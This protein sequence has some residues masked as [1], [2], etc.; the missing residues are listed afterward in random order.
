MRS[1]HYFLAGLALGAGLLFFAASSGWVGEAAP[2]AGA[3]GDGEHDEHGG[4]GAGGGSREGHGAAV[5][6]A[7]DAQAL[8]GVETSPVARRA[9]SKTISLPAEVTIPAGRL[10]H[11]GA[12]VEGTIHHV[13]V[14]LGDAVN[15]GDLLVEIDSLVMGEAKAAYLQV[16]AERDLAEK[17]LARERKLAGEGGSARKDL[18]DAEA[19]LAKADIALRAARDRLTLL[20]LDE[21][22]IA[23]V[24]EEKGEERSH[25]PVRA[26]MTG[27]VIDRHATR[28]EVA[29]PEERLF[30]LA[31]L[32]EVWVI[33]SVAERD[34]SL[35]RTGVTA[36]ARVAADPDEVH[37]GTLTYVAPE[38]DPRTR[39]IPVRVVTPNR[40]GRLKPGMFAEVSL[41]IDGETSMLVVP[42]AA[43]VRVD[44]RPAVF[45]AEEGGRFERRM[46]R[47][48]AETRDAVEL[49][50]GV[51]EGER[52]VV[53]GAFLLK[54]ELE[55]AS[56]ADGH[57]D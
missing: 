32:D 40:G 11:V 25:V 34:L 21:G 3:R 2:A 17:S 47:T 53:K 52:I 14:E 35:L 30:T 36:T 43:I 31:S 37:T 45:V 23:R 54:S 28:G 15:E 22:G 56:L 18:L 13:L 27:V 42:R 44:G 57:V 1:A 26:P 24:P 29:H 7:P 6:L 49:E 20:G 39:R 5:T 9:M 12:R 51:A 46:V 38:V 48:G 4:H 50:A 41:P 55:R 16:M 19:S 10:A 33:A 8:A